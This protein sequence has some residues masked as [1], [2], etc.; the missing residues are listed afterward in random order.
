M[1]PK[2]KNRPQEGLKARTRKS[3]DVITPFLD[4][5]L[6]CPWRRK[7]NPPPPPKTRVYARQIFFKRHPFYISSFEGKYRAQSLVGFMDLK[8]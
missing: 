2:S 8:S 3:E 1:A 6:K 7:G 4:V 5:H